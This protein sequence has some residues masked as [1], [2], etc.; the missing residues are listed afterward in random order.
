VAHHLLY[1]AAV[2]SVRSGRVLAEVL[3]ECP[4][5]ADIDIS[6][7]TDPAGYLGE[8]ADYILAETKAAE[9]E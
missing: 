4:E 9:R 5:L 8:A 2:E 1:D 7:L 6:A 3:G